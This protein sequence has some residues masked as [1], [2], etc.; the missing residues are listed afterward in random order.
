MKDPNEDFFE[1]RDVTLRAGAML[2][3]PD[4]GITD[5]LARTVIGDGSTSFRANDGDSPDCVLAFIVRPCGAMGDAA[6]GKNRLMFQ[7]PERIHSRI[8]RP[9][10]G[11]PV[12]PVQRGLI[13]YPVIDD[14]IGR[15]G[16]GSAPRGSAVPLFLHAEH[17]ASAIQDRIIAVIGGV[18]VW[19]S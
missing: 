8:V 11:Y 6:G 16:H 7:Q 19:V 5:H 14:Q 13:R 15:R 1:H 3:Q 18:K 10:P 2:F 4:N 17:P 9:L 12:L